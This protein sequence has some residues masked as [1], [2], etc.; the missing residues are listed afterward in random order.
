[1]TDDE[2]QQQQQL[3]ALQLGLQQVSR[4]TCFPL[5]PP[6][7]RYHLR[8]LL[9]WREQQELLL[10]S[11][12]LFIASGLLSCSI[13]MQSSASASSLPILSFVGP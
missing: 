12:Q 5:L 13:C 1:M 10:L 9:H 2:Q 3:A 4:L 6:L 11:W 8:L 7:P